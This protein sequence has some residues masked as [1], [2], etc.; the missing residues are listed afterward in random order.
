MSTKP[1]LDEE[2]MR[3]IALRKARTAKLL[4]QREV[5]NATGTHQSNIG[6]YERGDALLTLARFEEIMGAIQKLPKAKGRATVMGRPRKPSGVTAF[7][8]C[9]F[10]NEEQSN[11]AR[12]L[13]VDERGQAL[14]NYLESRKLQ[15]SQEDTWR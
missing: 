3:G 12:Q 7:L 8:Y 1:L 11:Q 9:R 5:A 13:S 4:S 14:I 6:A 10:E 2:R 15:D